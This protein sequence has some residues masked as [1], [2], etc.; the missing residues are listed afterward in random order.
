MALIEHFTFM[1]G[2]QRRFSMPIPLVLVLVL[3]IEG[4]KVEDED[5]NAFASLRLCVKT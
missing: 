1:A 5:E 2:R 4:G 3:A